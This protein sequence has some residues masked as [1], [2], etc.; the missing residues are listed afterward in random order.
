M[1]HPK[2]LELLLDGTPLAIERIKQ[3]WSGLSTS[4][5]VYL[6]SVWITDTSTDLG[7]QRW[8]HHQKCL[9]DLA[10]A[11]S[12]P[13]V[14]YLAAKTVSEPYKADDAE[15]TPDYLKDKARFEKVQADP[16]PL[17]RSASEEGFKLF[18]LE[19]DDPKSFWKRPQTERLALV[20]GVGEEGENLAKLLRYAT[21]DLLPSK[22]IT[23]DEMLDV[24][25]QYLG[26]Q[27]I[28][29]RVAQ[30]ED[31]ADRFRDG[32]A[33]YQVGESVKELWE[34]IPEL[35]KALSYALIDSLPETA[36]LMSDIPPEVIES[37]DEHQLEQLLYR[38]DITLKKLRR[39]LFKNSTNKNLREAAVA[40]QHFELRDSDISKLVYDPRES[41]E[42]G[43]KKV[44][45]LA[46]LATL[47]RGATLVQMQAICYLINDA[48]DKFHSGLGM[49][50]TI[51]FGETLQTQRAKRLSS[52][53]L[54]YEVVAMRLFERAKSL[55]PIK[56]D[57]SPEELSD[58]LIRLKDLIVSQNP[59]QTY[60]NLK[61]D[62]PLSG[63][64]RMGSY[65]PEVY[66]R[67]VDLPKDSSENMDEA[68][69][70]VFDLLKDVSGRVKDV[71]EKDRAEL[72]SLS[73]A[74][75]AIS[76]QM[77]D[78]ETLTGKR[79][80]AL[81]AQIEKLVQT[82]NILHVFI[83]LAFLILTLLLLIRFVVDP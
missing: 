81:Q 36:G 14:R 6:L 74:I 2:H 26:S 70:Q 64:K 37:L 79:V 3:A 23:I 32:F 8:S 10:L 53:A 82:I 75:T 31:L 77:A 5:R 58:E 43:K 22:E 41:E 49:W 62:V 63:W 56:M 20:N 66:I 16:V 19:L 83:V 80:A 71:S 38:N 40:S 39:K 47:C 57:E 67:D 65:L 50:A 61:K 52:D 1:T 73:K 13:Y 4:D 24:L 48:P 45:E 17:V 54:H 11:D 30:S 68:G 7:F 55:S 44:N 51:G 59:W 28:G 72:S 35:P 34:V 12:N 9:I 15:E 18:S 69:R 25:L 60:L 29:K 33:A 21:K 46:M 76:S 78:S 27:G 42:A